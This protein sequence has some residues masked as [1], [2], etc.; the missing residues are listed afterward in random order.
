MWL[1]LTG[2]GLGFTVSCK[3]VGLFTIATIGTS[4]L[5]GLWELWGNTRVSSG[6]FLRH[7]GARA[8]CLI[9]LPITVY[10]LMFKI[11]FHI[12]PNSGEGDGFMSPEFQQTL[13]G[14][15]SINTPVGKRLFYHFY[16]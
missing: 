6:V 8:L 7:F 1:A 11:H 10:M 14:H 12:L 5:K 9:V 3:W 15:T 4:T 2:L 16:D 13:D